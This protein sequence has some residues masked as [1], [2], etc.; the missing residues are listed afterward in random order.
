M[1]ATTVEINVKRAELLEMLVTTE[2]KFAVCRVG[3]FKYSE[4]LNFPGYSKTKI[5]FPV[6]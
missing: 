3:E 1:L 6:P 2:D 4:Y 5:L